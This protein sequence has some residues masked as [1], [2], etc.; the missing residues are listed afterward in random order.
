MKIDRTNMKICSRCH[1]WNDDELYYRANWKNTGSR[2]FAICNPC[3]D[4]KKIPNI[5]K[6]VEELDRKFK[7]KNFINPFSIEI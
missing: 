6:K 1:K 2:Y 5:I 3:D 4:L 7:K